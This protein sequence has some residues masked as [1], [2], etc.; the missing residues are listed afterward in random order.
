MLFRSIRAAAQVSR[1]DYAPFEGMELSGVIEE[2]YLRG[3]LTVRDGALLIEKRGKFLK[4]RK[5]EAVL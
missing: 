4:R 5:F 1:C 3:A 2:V